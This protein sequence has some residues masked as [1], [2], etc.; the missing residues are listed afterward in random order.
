ML[1]CGDT[2]KQLAIKM[3]ERLTKVIAKNQATSEPLYMA[4]LHSK[5]PD[6]AFNY[7]EFQEPLIGCTGLKTS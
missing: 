6:V 1:K 4:Q 2:V 7:K 5:I 3:K